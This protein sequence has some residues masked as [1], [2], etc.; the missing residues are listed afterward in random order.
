M[1]LWKCVK[2]RVR[3]RETKALKKEIRNHREERR[4]RY[5]RG[6]R[7]KD[8]TKLLPTRRKGLGIESFSVVEL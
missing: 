2:L 1:G 6:Y 3:L 5:G 7:Q 4:K 8:T